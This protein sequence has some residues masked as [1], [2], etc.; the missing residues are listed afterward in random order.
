MNIWNNIN[1]Y[2]R[3]FAMSEIK[4]YFSEEKFSSVTKDIGFLITAVINSHGELDFQIRPGNKI[5]IYYK[6]NS[7]AEI[8]FNKNLYKIKVHNKFGLEKAAAKDPLKRFSAYEFIEEGDYVS[9]LVDRELIYAFLQKKVLNYLMSE[10]KVI[11]NGEEISFEQSL[12]TDNLNRPEYIIIDRQVGGGGMSGI[13]DLL[14]LRQTSTGKYHLEAVE[15]KLGN[16]KELRKDVFEQIDRYVKAIVE[17]F[18]AFK[19][20]Y[21]KNYAQK[22]ALGLFPKDWIDS[23]EILE[24]V[25][26]KIVVG[27]YYQI[28]G[29]YKDELQTNFPD[30]PY[31]FH[32]FRNLIS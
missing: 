9:V 20:C 23:I 11:N 2:R 30:M 19:L 27:S 17:N 18:Q 1:S 3:G 14:A 29:K 5:N 12:I 24:N 31:S 21:E 32:Q 22:K 7:L 16:N 6:G 25:T 28:G 26:G 10:I 13:L 8:S 4:R 15:V